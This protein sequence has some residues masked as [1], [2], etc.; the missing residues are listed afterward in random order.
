MCTATHKD[1]K[2]K[3]LV[4]DGF[5]INRTITD[6]R[7]LFSD[8]ED[9]DSFFALPN[10][11]RFGLTDIPISTIDIYSASPLHSYTCI[12]RWFNLLIYHLN[13]E[14]LSWSPTSLVIKQSMKFLQTLIQEKTGLKVDQPDSSG[15]TTSTGNVARR[16]F[17]DET[18]F[19]VCVLSTIAIPHRP[20]LA[21]IHNQL[22]AI[23]RVYNSGRK[24]NTVELGKLCKRHL[25]ID[26]RFISLGEYHTNSTQIIS[27]L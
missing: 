26:F 5:P 27:P 9:T 19:V 23:L 21:K 10:T 2:D 3:V 16:A 22:A 12:F 8:I 20:A 14:K 25:S 4:V 15:G 1:L 24:V 18:S 17:S 13:I 6:A 11:E 7:Q